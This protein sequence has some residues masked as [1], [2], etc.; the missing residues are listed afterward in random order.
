MKCV[1]NQCRSLLEF[2]INS[3]GFS[4]W[5]EFSAGTFKNIKA[6]FDLELIFF[7]KRENFSGKA[8]PGQ[9]I[10]PITSNYSETCL[11]RPLKNR[12]NKGLKAMW[13]LN[14]G[15]KYCRMLPLEHSAI[16]LPCIKR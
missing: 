3:F 8:K 1:I 5:L 9:C 2:Y 12:Q 7:P 13:W 6:Y 11:N 15:Q 10:H 14:A 16:L 4:H